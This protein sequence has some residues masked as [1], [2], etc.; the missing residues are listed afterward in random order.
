MNSTF[1]PKNGLLLLAGLIVGFLSCLFLSKVTLWGHFIPSA[2]VATD[3]S[4]ALLL[5]LLIGISISIWP[6]PREDRSLLVGLWIIR[7]FVVLGAMLLYENNYGLD[8]YTYY[9]ESKDFSYNWNYVGFGNG[10]GNIGL[11]IWYLNKFLPAENSYHS[12]KVIFSL[13]GMAAVYLFYRAITIYSGRTWPFLL[14]FLGTFP[15]LV[16]WSSIL[17]K[18]PIVFFGISL[19]CAGTLRC[20]KS[21]K[22][23]W[24]L[25]ALAGV[26]IAASI[27]PWTAFI[28]MVP[29]ITI[30]FFHIRDGFLKISFLV[31]ASI[32]VYQSALVFQ[33]H[34]SLGSLDELVH[35]TNIISK[36]WSI[37]GSRQE[38]PEFHSLQ[39]MGYFAPIGM[40]TALFRPLPF[41]VPNFFGLLAGL[42]NAVLLFLLVLGIKRFSFSKL[43]NPAVIWGLVLLIAWSAVYAFVSYQNLGSASRFRLQVLPVLLAILI[44]LARPPV[45]SIASDASDAGAFPK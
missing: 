1:L 7:C 23:L 35:K 37:G 44:Y 21:P 16:F 34:F 2:N 40:F 24:I 28:L 27:R 10:T 15:S 13:I 14:A 22:V 17:G 26:V 41:E 5:A 42:E 3:Y 12:I 25:M 18:D 9:L 32:L 33:D 29:G 6:V 36:A 39:E 38:V 45:D 11:I 8:A 19:Y 20:M 30:G 31:L 43:K 4:W